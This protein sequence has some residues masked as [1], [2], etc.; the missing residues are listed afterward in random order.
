MD[1]RSIKLHLIDRRARAVVFE[2]TLIG[3]DLEGA[4]YAALEEAAQPLFAAL[5]TQLGQAC[6]T[7]LRALSIDFVSGT[8]RLSLAGSSEGDSGGVVMKR[9]EYQKFLPM[10]SSLARTVGTKLRAPRLDREGS[11]SDASYWEALYQT[12]Q[13]GWELGRAAPPLARWFHVHSPAHLRTLVVG[14]GRGHEARC[15]AALGADVTALDFSASANA[16]AEKLAA[17]EGLAISFQEA[18]LFTFAPAQLFDLVVEHT[19]FCAIEPHQRKQ[20]VQAI[21]RL[22]TPGGRLV[23]LFYAHNRP[24]GPAFGTNETELMSLFSPV[25]SLEH[26][27]I[28][29]DSIA[30]RLGEE[31]LLCWRKPLTI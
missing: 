19:C 1:L 16:E 26:K 25:F 9:E 11:P 27:E 21:N 13:D 7:D 15:L 5:E 22:L 8:I 3:R 20:Y 4:D 24:G 29:S 17:A 30:T 23:G 18:N 10:L 2:N 31:L 12:G 14:S 28:P 6:H